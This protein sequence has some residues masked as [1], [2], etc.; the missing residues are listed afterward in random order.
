M[1]LGDEQATASE[2]RRLSMEW[3]GGTLKRQE[4]RT[5]AKRD[6]LLVEETRWNIYPKKLKQPFQCKKKSL[7]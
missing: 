3:V 2:M 7:N 5:P 6:V 1:H 4:N